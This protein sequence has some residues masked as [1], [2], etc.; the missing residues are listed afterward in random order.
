[1]D[2]RYLENTASPIKVRGIPSSRATVAVHLPVP[3]W[4]AVS[5]ILSTRYVPSFSLNLSISAVI[6]IR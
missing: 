2:E 1:M 5:K 3:F 6:S 4:P